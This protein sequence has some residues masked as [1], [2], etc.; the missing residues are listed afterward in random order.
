MGQDK[1]DSTVVACSCGYQ[2]AGSFE[3]FF[4]Q[5]K[6]VWKTPRTIRLPSEFAITS[7][8]PITV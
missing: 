6:L 8:L 5:G 7:F 1:T 2:S 3:S 4:I